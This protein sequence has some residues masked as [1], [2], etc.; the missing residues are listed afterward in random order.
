MTVV[1]IGKN[2]FLGQA[3]ASHLDAKS[4]RFISHAEARNPKSYEGATCVVNFALHGDVKKGILTPET[5]LDSA[6]ATLIKNT[7]I[8]YVVISSR[9]VYGPSIHNGPIF[10]TDPLAPVSGYGKAKKQIEENVTNILGADRVTLLRLTTIF[11]FETDERRQSFFSMA[12]CKLLSEGRIEYNMNP[13]VRRDFLSV[14]RCADALVK[15]C[16]APKSGAFNIGSGIDL[17]T[18]DVAAWLFESYGAGELVVV[19]QEYKDA[20][21]FDMTKTRETFGTKII[22]REDLKQDCLA[23]GTA[24]RA[25]ANQGTMEPWKNRH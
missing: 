24:L 14:D 15:I 10:E 12:L 25:L 18:A 6:I 22:T 23:L 21:W 19:N 7:N 4:W 1:A 9:T 20:F 16:N 5:D 2:S 3:T 13:Q 17:E 8:H 11:G